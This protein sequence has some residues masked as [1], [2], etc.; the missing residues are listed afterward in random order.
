VIADSKC[1][2]AAIECRACSPALHSQQTGRRS[3]RLP[4]PRVRIADPKA[5]RARARSRPAAR[6]AGRRPR[7]VFVALD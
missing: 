5:K 4:A 2:P 6:L 7:E 3:T 1:A